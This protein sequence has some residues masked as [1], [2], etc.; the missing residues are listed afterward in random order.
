MSISTEV[1]GSKG[2]IMKLRFLSVQAIAGVVAATLVGSG[3]VALATDSVQFANN[4]VTSND[5]VAEAAMDLQF[6]PA[7]VDDGCFGQGTFSD[8]PFTAALSGTFDLSTGAPANET[9]GEVDLIEWYCVRN[10]GNI[11]GQLSLVNT[12]LDDSEI[13]CS[14]GEADL[15]TTCGSGDGDLDLATYAV[16]V[17]PIQENPA[18]PQDQRTLAP[19]VYNTPQPSFTLAAGEE[20]L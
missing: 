17:F 8:G 5:F 7:I 4:E 10:V 18:C 14:P 13:D 6:A 11:N 1:D 16:L 20:C 3:V 12:L 9:G 2:T 19:V 15:D